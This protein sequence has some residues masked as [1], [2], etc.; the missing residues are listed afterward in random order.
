MAYFV[1][2]N[3]DALIESL[4]RNDDDSNNNHNKYSPIRAGDHLMQK[5]LASMMST[6]TTDDNDAAT[7]NVYSREEL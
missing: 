6:R 2:V 5:H 1:S 3:G 7:A 4:Q